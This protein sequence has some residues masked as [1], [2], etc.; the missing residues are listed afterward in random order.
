VASCT[1]GYYGAAG[2]SGFGLAA[3]YTDQNFSLVITDIDSG[4]PVACG[5]ILKPDADEFTQAGMALVEL[6]PVGDSGVSGYA[7][8]ERVALQRELDVTPTR[9][10]VLLFA[11]PASQ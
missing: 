3:A 11:P 10:R 9:M 7:L 2:A 8:V 6:L 5:D 1:G 4:D